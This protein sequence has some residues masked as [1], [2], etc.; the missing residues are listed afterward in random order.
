[1]VMPAVQQTGDDFQTAFRQ[2][3]SL[4]WCCSGKLGL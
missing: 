3:M 1:M 2:S 4:V